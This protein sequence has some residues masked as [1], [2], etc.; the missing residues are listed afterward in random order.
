MNDEYK[1]L[2][3]EYTSEIKV[4]GSKFIATAGP[5]DTVEKAAQFVTRLSKRF[6]DATHNCYAY[7]IRTPPYHRYHD[8]GEPGGTAGKPIYQ[9]ILKNNL[10]DV[11]IVVT[12]YFGGT[13]L[14]TGGLV[15]AYSDSAASVLQNAKIITKIIFERLQIKFPYEAT[16]TVMRLI[17]SLEGKIIE[18]D[19]DASTL[20]SVEIRL[21]AVSD[22]KSRLVEA[23]AGK[24]SFIGNENSH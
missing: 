5:T 23:T 3:A 20:V 4:K 9:T 24:V 10:T 17:S 6:F 2:R 12:R 15:R 16:N 13:K 7:E 8:D 19:Y 14:G 11:S 1:T 21:S 18:T 22:F